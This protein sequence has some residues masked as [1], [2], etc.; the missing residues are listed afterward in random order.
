MELPKVHIL[1]EGLPIKSFDLKEGANS[2]GRGEDNLIHLPESSISTNHGVFTVVAGKVT[3]KDLDS[4]NG[5]FIEDNQ[6]TEA[7]LAPGTVFRLGT[8]DFQL[9]GSDVEIDKNKRGTARIQV[10]PKTGEKTQ[11]IPQ[12]A[13]PFRVKSS[14][15]IRLYYYFIALMIV[16]IIGVLVWTI[17]L[18]Q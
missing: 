3:F 17:I 11:T 1:T 16:A 14:R 4:T 10:M 7:E 5:S 15:G 18:T 8:I 13:S 9:G 6:I 2:I 12:S